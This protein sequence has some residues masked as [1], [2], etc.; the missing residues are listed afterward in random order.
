MAFLKVDK[1]IF[2]GSSFVISENNSFVL[3]IGTIN[4]KF[5]DSTI[6]ITVA[7]TSARAMARPHKES[8]S[9]SEAKGPGTATK[10]SQRVKNQQLL[11]QQQEYLSKHITSNGPQDKERT[12]PLDF[13]SLDDSQLVNYNIKYELNLP[14]PIKVNEDILDSDIGRKTHYKRNSK[15]AGRISKAELASRVKNHFENFPVKENEIIT[16]FLYK[17]KHQDEEFKLS[18]K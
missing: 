8:A 9:D 14:L 5:H 10:T 13:E 17:V 12:D 4:A 15:F 1:L 7:T 3:P 16:N 6:S 18:F 11:Q 2:V